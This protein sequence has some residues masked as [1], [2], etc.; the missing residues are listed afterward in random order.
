MVL[1][2]F[3][4]GRLV[5]HCNFVTLLT[6]PFIS[7]SCSSRPV[8]YSRSSVEHDTL[9]QALQS[10]YSCSPLK[11]L[12][13][14]L[15]HCQTADHVSTRPTACTDTVYVQCL[16]LLLAVKSCVQLIGHTAEAVKTLVTGWWFDGGVCTV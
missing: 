13:G 16:L 4:T 7:E 9:L 8:P 1:V 10:S 2:I 15:Q 11:P 3:W 12:A 14:H 6:A 5:S